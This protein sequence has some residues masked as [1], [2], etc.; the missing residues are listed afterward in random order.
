M[1][2][3]DNPTIHREI[4]PW[5]KSQQFPQEQLHTADDV[6]VDVDVDLDIGIGDEEEDI[7]VH[8]D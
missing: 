6:D 8:A 7:P 4:P 1:L 2:L 3:I 5:Q